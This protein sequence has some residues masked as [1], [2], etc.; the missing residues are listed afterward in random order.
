M[1]AELERAKARRGKL[2]ARVAK[3]RMLE[4]ELK[5]ADA[6]IAELVARATALMKGEPSPERDA[7]GKD[8]A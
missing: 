7:A 1:V 6:E 4:A 3:A 2:A 8:G 5:G